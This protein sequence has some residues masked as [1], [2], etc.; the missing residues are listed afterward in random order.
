MKFL[1]LNSKKNVRY[2]KYNCA[3]FDYF[4]YDFFYK[5]YENYYYYNYYSYFKK[6]VKSRKVLKKAVNGR[7]RN[8]KNDSFKRD[9]NINIIGKFFNVSVRDGNKFN[10]IKHWNIFV[11]NFFDSF[12][13]S[14]ENIIH[15]KNYEAISELLS[16]KKVYYNFDILLNR[17]IS[18]F[19]PLF[20]VKI[21]KANKRIRAKYNK[22]YVYNII[23]IK[24]RKR[25]KH[26]LKLINSYSERFKNYTYW[27]RLYWMFV[28]ILLD[29]RNSFLLKRKLFV[30]RTALKKLYKKN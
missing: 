28:S 20:N 22:K 11:N 29:P 17:S 1:N 27:E 2:V 7:P 9:K 8:D 24:R 16:T 18:L 23:Y 19:E 12:K 5:N 25:L 15:Y 3:V 13:E 10:L 30:Y 4:N 21:N 26:V 6:N 14:N